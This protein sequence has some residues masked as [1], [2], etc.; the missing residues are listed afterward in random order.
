MNSI[1]H[2]IAFSAVLVHLWTGCGRCSALD[3]EGRHHHC[4]RTIIDSCEGKMSPA[5]HGCS[6]GGE[7]KM[8]ASHHE[9][10]SSEETSLTCTCQD[11]APCDGSSHSCQCCECVFV[12]PDTTDGPSSPVSKMTQSMVLA[13]RSV[14]LL[15]SAEFTPR[16]TFYVPSPE[17]VIFDP[18][19]FR[20]QI[21]VFL[22]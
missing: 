8:S 19:S 21:S 3:A 2:I 12:V 18:R 10:A 9:Q 20:A 6:C 15:S 13:L 1:F 22:L 17:D 14:V 11:E 16:P 7:G 5:P 4:H